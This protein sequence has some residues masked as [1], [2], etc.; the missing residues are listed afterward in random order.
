V[1]R[2]EV[3][4]QARALSDGQS[5][6]EF[7]E[8]FCSLT[9]ST[10]AGSMGDPL[11]L[12]QWQ[13]DLLLDLFA[14]DPITGLRLFRT[15]Y[16]GMPRK[17]G[18]SALGACIA[19]YELYLGIAGTE[20]YSVANSRDQAK[21]VFNMA[22][23]MVLAH[24]ELARDAK[25]YRD[26]ISYRNSVY[27]VLAAEAHNAEGL[28][29]NLVVFDEVHTQAN[30][31]L[32]DTMSLG[33]GARTEP[34]MLGITTAGVRTD[35]TGADSLGYSLYAYGRQVVA[36]E[37]DDPSFY[38][39][40]W[41]PAHKDCDHKSEAAWQEANPGYGDLNNPADFQAQCSRIPE[42]EFRTKRLNQWVDAASSWLPP[43]AWEA[44]T[45][46]T[47]IVADR[48]PVVVGFDGSYSNDSTGLVACTLDG[49]LF[50]LG[51]WERPLHAPEGWKVPIA[52]VEQAI[53]AAC[54]RYDVLE[55]V[56][57]PYRWARTMEALADEGLPIIAYPNSPQRMIP[58]CSRF[59]DAV[60]ESTITHDGNS[61][62]AA[63]IANAVFKMTQAGGYITKQAK[64]S[65]RK[66]DL[67]ICAVMAFDR[68]S[69]VTPTA[70]RSWLMY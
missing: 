16:V 51:V 52:E 12:R 38:F 42:A 48:T 7:I 22:K 2:T 29:P 32:W 14:K 34:L 10:V 47:K 66:I 57:D 28:N 24:P 5:V 11:V 17:N 55:V 33:S 35:A 36:R 64:N 6:A 54:Q 19:L 41:E 63:H 46:A 3:S 8:G 43:G 70:K 31:E 40:W 45:D 23:T 27:R 9:T 60:A 44:R 26:A 58:A 65:Q 4:P 62:L 59:S 21:L 1:H 69:Q 50:T 18:K 37:V 20:V 13:R 15:A 49:H 39:C 67:A 68:A 30:R 53:R 25:V 56:C 61:R